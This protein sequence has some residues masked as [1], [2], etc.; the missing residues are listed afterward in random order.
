MALKHHFCI[1]KNIFHQI[2]VQRYKKILKRPNFVRILIIKI[3]CAKLDKKKLRIKI[4]K[5]RILFGGIKKNSYFCKFFPISGFFK[6]GICR[7]KRFVETVFGTVRAGEH[8]RDIA[9]KRFG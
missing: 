5:L 2:S 6:S 8:A 7:F 9:L 4:F 3:K 1:F